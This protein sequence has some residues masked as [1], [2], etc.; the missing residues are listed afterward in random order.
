MWIQI[1]NWY[2]PAAL[3]LWKHFRENGVWKISLFHA[4]SSY[5][6]FLTLI[7]CTGRCIFIEKGSVVFFQPVENSAQ[8]CTHISIFFLKRATIVMMNYN[9]SNINTLYIT[10]DISVSINHSSTVCIIYHILLFKYKWYYIASCFYSLN[11]Q[12]VV[13]IVSISMYRM[14]YMLDKYV[15]L[16]EIQITFISCFNHSYST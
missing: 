9:P 7:P 16:G 8:S 4:T 13:E 5:I 12:F 15:S 10:T 14:S 6:F 3:S 1:V 2:S 11:Q